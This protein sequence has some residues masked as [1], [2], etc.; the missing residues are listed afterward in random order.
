VIPL[1]T[2]GITGVRCDPPG[3]NGLIAP[4]FTL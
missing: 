3:Y 2:A 1:S 4:A